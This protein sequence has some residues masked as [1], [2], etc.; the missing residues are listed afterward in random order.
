MRR[1]TRELVF[2]CHVLP[3]VLRSPVSKEALWNVWEMLV[4][5]LLCVCAFHL[6][7]S[8]FYCMCVVRGP[9]A[10]VSVRGD[11]TVF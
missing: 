7:V 10:N 8:E 1:F 2:L 11:L 9:I 3:L 4:K 6:L 5:A